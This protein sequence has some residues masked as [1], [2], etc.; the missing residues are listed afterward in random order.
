MKK[1]LVNFIIYILFFFSYSGVMAYEEANYTVIKKTKIYEIRKYSD[2]LVI[3][4]ISINNDNSFR[5]LFGYISG[6]NDQNEKIKM[7]V[8]VTQIIKKNKITMQF[9]LPSKFNKDNVP[10]PT[11][12]D[13]NITTIKGG[14]Y[15]VTQ[16][17]GRASDE[18][19]IKYKLILEKALIE[20]NIS[21]I[22]PG[23]KATYNSPFTLPMLRRNEVMFEVNW[24]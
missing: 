16:Y 13:I 6:Q 19:F 20:E 10:N 4:T 24:N 22:S 2:R 21:I 15:A 7:T 14:V 18:N 11:R 17:S 8:P 1:Y 5:K 23:I 3:Q 9:F 12:S